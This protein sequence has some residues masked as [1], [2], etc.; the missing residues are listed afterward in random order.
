MEAGMTAG[1]KILYDLGNT[2]GELTGIVG[3]LKES[4][5]HLRESTTKA[6][7]DHEKHC[8]KKDSIPP[9]KFVKLSPETRSL[10]FKIIVFLFIASEAGGKEFI[11]KIIGF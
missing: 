10:I 5:D 8:H 3:S 1:E 11:K 4:V 2:V 9:A 6:M 7:D